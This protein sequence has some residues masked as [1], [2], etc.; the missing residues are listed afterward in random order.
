MIFQ[1]GSKVKRFYFEIW[2]D[3]I[4]AMEKSKANMTYKDKAFILLILF[5]VAQGFNLALV[6]LIL[7]KYI[8][9]PF[10][11][12]IDI[13][14]GKFLDGAIAG[15]ITLFLPFVLI[16]YILIFRKKI[17]KKYVKNRK[18]NTKGKAL[19]AYFLLSAGLF[20][21]IV[22]IGKWII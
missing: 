3:A 5:S 19:L 13:F 9:T 4:E 21:L 6:L 10:F 12:P 14:P 1:M 18:I 17:V 2:A 8:K 16:N 22:V 11:L 15:I 20:I 7:S